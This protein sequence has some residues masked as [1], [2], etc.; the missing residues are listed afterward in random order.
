LFAAVE[1][2][3]DRE[4]QTAIVEPGTFDVVALRQRLSGDNDLMTDVIRVFL[5][6]LPVRLA[7]IKDAVTVRDAEAL[8]DAAHALKGAAANLSAGGLFEAARAIEQVAVEGR[9]NAADA[10]WRH[11]A[12]EANNVIDELRRQS[13]SGKEPQSCAS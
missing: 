1:Q 12:V 10:A 7:A 11:L 13:P 5:D 8:R 4:V 9:V 3:D 6:D 2:G